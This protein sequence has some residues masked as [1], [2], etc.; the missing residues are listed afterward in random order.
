[1]PP[2]AT[3]G[4]CL[5]LN[6]H[7]VARGAALLF[8]TNVVAIIL[9][10]A[11]SLYASG[12]RGK[13]G[14]SSKQ[15]WVFY[16]FFVLLL[17][18]AGLVVPLRSG[19]LS[20][21]SGGAPVEIPATLEASL[22]ERLESHPGAVIDTVTSRRNENGESVVEIQLTAPRPLPDELIGDLAGI[23]RAELGDEHVVRVGTRL[24]VEVR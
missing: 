22:T 10:A 19:W 1:M 24:A 11:V 20:L 5:A 21:L 23:A 3:T 17:G 8:G 2:I 18:A 16:S 12:V 15:S 4:S 7:G 13:R 14:A 6:E 9:G